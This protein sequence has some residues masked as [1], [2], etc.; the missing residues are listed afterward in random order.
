MS[1]QTSEL[2]ASRAVQSDLLRLLTGNPA[3]GLGEGTPGLRDS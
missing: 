3:Q 2:S 1:P